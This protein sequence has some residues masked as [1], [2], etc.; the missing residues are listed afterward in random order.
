MNKKHW[1]LETLSC[2]VVWL[3]STLIFLALTG[4]SLIFTRYFAADYSAEIPYERIACFP[5]TLLGAVALGSAIWWISGRISEEEEKGK[6]QVRRLLIGVL[7]WCLVL[8][9]GWVLLAISTPV[10]DQMMI[11]S[12]AERFAEGNYGRLDYGKYLYYY[13][14]RSGYNR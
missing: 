13:P 3:L 4:T 5:L 7:L 14:L 10:A 1:T 12:S 2:K 9:T 11:T 6:K 8:G